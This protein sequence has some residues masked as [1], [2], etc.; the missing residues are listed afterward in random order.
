[1][2]PKTYQKQEI[3]HYK[4]IVDVFFSLGLIIKGFDAL[5]EV[6]AGIFIFSST[7]KIYEYIALRL[8]NRQFLQDPT[9]F[10]VRSFLNTASHI[11][12]ASLHFA[13]IYLI[14]HGV[15]KLFIVLSLFAKKAWAYPTAITLLILF[16]LYQLYR[17]IFTHSVLL[18]ILSV[19]DIII[20]WLI[21]Q[22]YRMLLQ[23][24]IKFK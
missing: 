10:W 23:A 21:W 15:I 24:K 3:S 12:V 14:I 11:S 4:K 6:I 9:D 1:M 22:E 7:S 20:V 18:L 19:F 8:A 13:A 2:Q 17:Y 5:L 16:I